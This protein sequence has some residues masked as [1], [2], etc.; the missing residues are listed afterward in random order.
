MDYITQ[1]IESIPI[2]RHCTDDEIAYLKNISRV[3][4]VKKGQEI[5]IKKL[6]SL[7]IIAEGIF[8]SEML[9]KKEM[10]YLSPGSFFGEIPFSE[11]KN[12]GVI[13]AVAESRLIHLGGEDLYKFFLLYYKA[14]RGYIRI[15]DKLGFDISGMAMD[16]LSNR[17]RIITVFSMMRDSGK[18]ILSAC[19]AQSLSGS[20]KTIIL[21][22]TT[23]GNSIFNIFEKDIPPAIS[24]KQSSSAPSEEIFDK[25]IEVN[26]NL[27]LLNITHGSM[28]NANPD[29]LSPILF[30]LSKKYKYV[31]IDLANSNNEIRDKAL[32]LSDVILPL[33]KRTRDMELLYGLLDDKITQGQRIYYVLNKHFS[34]HTDNL[35][36]GYILNDIKVLENDNL[37]QKISEQRNDDGIHGIT[38]NIISKKQGLVLDS[39]LH[40]S[41]LF[42]GLMTAVW[43][44]DTK[45][46][47]IYTSSY[48]LII[49]SLFLLCK[50][51]NEF[52]KWII[53]IFSTDRFKS[54]LDVTFPDKYIF[55]T[56]KV[57]KLAD[58][59]AGNAR[60]EFLKILA[61]TLA[62]DE[63]QKRRLFSTGYF[64]DIIAASIAMF[65]LFE[66]VEISNKYYTSGFPLHYARAQDLLRNDVDVIIHATFSRQKPAR[67]EGRIGFYNNY[68][69]YMHA[70][71][72]PY[73]LING[74]DYNIE[75]SI[76]ENEYN[77]E[78][79]IELS[80]E[81]AANVLGVIKKK[82]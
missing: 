28:V 57:F 62:A 63:K 19:M 29:I 73:G 10:L 25:I 70:L 30:L 76:D 64:R 56:D 48:N 55:K 79:I 71:I 65:P 53:R 58:E 78:K 5:D 67:N 81:I 77:I 44:S 27:S 74:T 26:E 18:T 59:I 43:G 2:F 54:I 80:E 34:P 38:E 32:E 8:E 82:L 33:L 1:I 7:N 39:A 49:A 72:R 9:G 11:N 23:D 15:I 68:V 46:D 3:S 47:V 66:P 45:I 61:I 12:R 16:H 41:V 31:I 40:K 13:K 75:I 14:L 50:D 17:T 24:Q 60:I 35:E 20:D 69:D 6:N 36:G 21:D 42:T 37:L 51:I 4:S 52:K 22:M